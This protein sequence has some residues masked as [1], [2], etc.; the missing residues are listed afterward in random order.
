MKEWGFLYFMFCD[1]SNSALDETGIEIVFWC[2]LQV[3]SIRAKYAELEKSYRASRD[4]TKQKL[5]D[6]KDEAD[7]KLLQLHDKFQSLC[8][9]ISES[10]VVSMCMTGNWFKR[11]R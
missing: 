9:E 2:A 6:Y 4:E 8:S 7:K 1:K 5:S 11:L 10:H 3:N